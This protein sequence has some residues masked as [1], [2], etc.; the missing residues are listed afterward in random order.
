MIIALRSQRPMPS[1]SLPVNYLRRSLEVTTP[2]AFTITPRQLSSP[3]G[4]RSQRPMPSPS[5]PVNYLRRQAWILYYTRHVVG[6]YTDFILVV[7]SWNV[8][9]FRD[10]RYAKMFDPLTRNIRARTPL[11]LC[12]IDVDISTR[13]CY[14]LLFVAQTGPEATDRAM[15]M[16]S[17]PQTKL[18][19]VG[20]PQSVC[21]LQMETEAWHHHKGPA[22]REW[23]FLSTLDTGYQITLIVHQYLVLC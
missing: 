20:I 21:W 12:M 8:P 5:L 7:S 23:I 18:T 10:Y 16:S 22:D 13:L 1:P 15:G 9:S 14:D 11:G 19:T 2:H 17:H 4:L 3:P 6:V